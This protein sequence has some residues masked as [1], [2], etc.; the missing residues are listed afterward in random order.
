MKKFMSLVLI[1]LL[2][3]STL[4]ASAKILYGA[5]KNLTTN[6]STTYVMFDV[7][8]VLLEH[9]F[10][11]GMMSRSALLAQAFATH[12]VAIT[13]A[14]AQVTLHKLGFANPMLDEL[15]GLRKSKAVGHQYIELFKKHKENG[16]AALTK[17]MMRAK[18]PIQETV[19]I[20]DQLNQNATIKLG[21]A[22]NMSKADFDYFNDSKSGISATFG[23]FD[24]TLEK[25]MDYKNGET[26]KKPATQ[27]F[28]DV[29][30]KITGHTAYAAQSPIVFIDDK[31]ENLDGFYTSLPAQQ[32]SNYIGIQFNTPAELK[33]DL[34]S[35]GLLKEKTE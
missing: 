23:G 27:Y 16:L 28:H 12:P 14:L 19:A 30:K 21:I 15:K 33:Q 32:Q 6:P 18:R 10:R 5:D 24:A 4:S 26:A 7:D 9:R 29:L 11:L 35:L 20:K 8:Q 34:L 2:G 1:S 31:K 3:L 17:E 22:T 25:T 13:R